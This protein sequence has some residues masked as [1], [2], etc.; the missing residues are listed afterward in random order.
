MASGTDRFDLALFGRARRRKHMFGV[1]NTTDNEPY[2]V[3]P[4]PPG[5]PCQ[6]P[7]QL[8]RALT[9]KLDADVP[10]LTHVPGVLDPD[11]H[12]VQHNGGPFLAA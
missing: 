3:C 6:G 2:G 8:N 1:S 4:F 12:A 9:Y 10:Q 7:T 11:A 5:R